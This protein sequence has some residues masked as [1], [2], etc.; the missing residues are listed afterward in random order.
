MGFPVGALSSVVECLEHHGDTVHV[1]DHR[2][3]GSAHDLD[4]SAI[5][6]NDLRAMLEAMERHPIGQI[7][8]PRRDVCSAI[9]ATCRGF[10]A[11]N[12]VIVA[13]NK[14]QGRYYLRVL[15]NLFGDSVGKAFGGICDVDTRIT[16]S[17]YKYLHVREGRQRVDI[18]LLPDATSMMSDSAQKQL[19]SIELAPYR[20]F[21]FV[22]P[23]SPFGTSRQ[24]RLLAEM[25]AGRAIWRTG[26][27]TARV[28]VRRPEMAS[29]PNAKG[30]WGI[31]RKR[32]LFW[33]NG[34]RNDRLTAIATAFAERDARRLFELG[35]EVP[36]VF[37]PTNDQP[38]NVSMLVESV[39]HGRELLRRLPEWRLIGGVDGEIHHGVRDDVARGRIVTLAYTTKHNIAAHVLIRASGN[40]PLNSIRGFPPSRDITDT[41]FLVEPADIP[42][43]GIS[44]APTEKIPRGVNRAG[45]P[46]H[47]DTPKTRRKEHPA[48]H[49]SRRLPP[50]TNYRKEPYVMKSHTAEKQ[51]PT[52]HP[53]PLP[54]FPPSL[55]PLP[56]E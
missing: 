44:P 39:E 12:I 48:V 36:E 50:Y 22:P 6:D 27:E 31:E 19:G 47:Q 17:G 38:W 33:T 10:P 42:Y 43:E 7:E 3:F 15:R 16:V 24:S 9:V 56:A 40:Y 55:H 13:A 51:T 2:Y 4:L 8:I 20:L 23:A 35:I 29:F 26:P 46:P 53:P 32:S 52:F 1:V 5:K 18:V 28:E 41:I 45:K 49:P 25:V 30:L 37:P 11:A 14:R 54:S 21:A 34:S